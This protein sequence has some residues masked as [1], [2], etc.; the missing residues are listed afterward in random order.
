M[1]NV[2]WRE[3]AKLAQAIGVLMLCSAL[4]VTGLTLPTDARADEFATDI[5][6]TT[7]KDLQS[8]YPLDLDNPIKIYR[9]SGELKKVKYKKLKIGYPKGA[10]RIDSPYRSMTGATGGIR[11]W[12]HTGIDLMVPLDTPVIAAADGLDVPALTGPV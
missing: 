4:T 12:P 6:E 3:A 10:T 8:K 5:V 7:L 9:K 2:D 1:A 11:D